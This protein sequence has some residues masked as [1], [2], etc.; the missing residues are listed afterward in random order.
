M[1]LLDE[2]SNAVGCVQLESREN[3]NYSRSFMMIDFGTHKLRLYAEEAEFAGDLSAYNVV[4]EV[5]CQYITKVR[6][7]QSQFLQG[8]I[9]G[10]AIP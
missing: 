1:P 5:N 10:R 9:S 3:G 8:I 7:Q 2:N 6:Y 4:L